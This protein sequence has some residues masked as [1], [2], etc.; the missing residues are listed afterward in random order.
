MPL[1]RPT[2]PNAARCAV[3]LTFDNFGESF[4]LLRHGH[5]GGAL[6][7][8]V[9]AP[10]RG[11]PRVLKLLERHQIPATFFVEGWNALRYRDLLRE[12]MERG[13]EVAA[14]GWMHEQW[15]TLEPEDERDLIVKAT[16]AIADATGTA[17]RGW[18]AP[19]GL[20][21]TET[22]R[23][24]HDA[25]YDWDSSFGDED[26]PYRMSIAADRDE[27]LLELPW[28]WSLDDAAYFAYPGSIR[29]PA[30]IAQLWIDEFD[31][32]YATTGYFVLVCHPRYIGRPARIEALETLIS[33]IRA[34]DGIWFA[35]CS[36]VADATR[37]ADWLP[38]YP[39]PAIMRPE[40]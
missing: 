23:C 27:T 1:E 35:H 26:V 15:N 3:I 29:R 31:A 18:R 19:S 2:R 24:I 25:G 36:E 16:A 11:V 21:T 13:H 5:A 32:A 8:G 7:D 30:D 20:T 4:D 22:L 34:H 28:Q 12:V 38:R 10:R 40:D 17:P 14:H 39:A 33:H 37:D 6:A 9:Y